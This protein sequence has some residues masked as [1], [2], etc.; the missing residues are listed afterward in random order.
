MKERDMTYIKGI[1]INE[2]ALFYN[3]KR[4]QMFTFQVK[5]GLK[6]IGLLE[7]NLNEKFKRNDQCFLRQA[8]TLNFTVYELFDF[9]MLFQ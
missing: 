2:D 5:V 4:Y 6:H 3:Q 7:P 9:I 8:V 1:I